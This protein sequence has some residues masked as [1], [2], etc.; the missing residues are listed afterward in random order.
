ME[1]IRLEAGNLSDACCRIANAGNRAGTVLQGFALEQSAL[2]RP[3]LL[4]YFLDVG[5]VQPAEAI[6]D[7]AVLLVAASRVFDG[8]LAAF[9]NDLHSEG[10]EACPSKPAPLIHYGS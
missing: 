1:S 5:G 4:V 9:Q 7:D 8:L 3:G 10:K 6:V 2:A